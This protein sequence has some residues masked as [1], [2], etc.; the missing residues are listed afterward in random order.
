M[1]GFLR[2]PRLA[3]TS[4]VSSHFSLRGL[5]A[6]EVRALGLRA[7]SQ[8]GSCPRLVQASHKP[9]LVFCASY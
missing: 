6:D 8:D 1:P 9:P 2:L 5:P 7:Q 4:W 3:D